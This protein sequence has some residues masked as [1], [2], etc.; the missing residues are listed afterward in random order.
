MLA[1]QH[2]EHGSLSARHWTV[3]QN[4]SSLIPGKR[5]IPGKVSV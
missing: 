1:L 5:L 4:V 2:S 3:I